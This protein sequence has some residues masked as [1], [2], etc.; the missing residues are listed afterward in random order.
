MPGNANRAEGRQQIE[1]RVRDG[2]MD[3]IGQSP[4]AKIMIPTITSRD[5]PA[6]IV[7]TDD[8]L[9]VISVEKISAAAVETFGGHDGG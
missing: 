1:S 7:G 6:F 2:I 9:F 8:G 3:Q 4:A 5:H